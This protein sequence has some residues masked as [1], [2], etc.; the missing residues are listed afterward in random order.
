MCT[1]RINVP[2]NILGMPY[3]GVI[4]SIATR[5]RQHLPSHRFTQSG[6]STLYVGCYLQAPFITWLPRW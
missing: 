1:Y 5:T 4:T 6:F 3:S 2:V